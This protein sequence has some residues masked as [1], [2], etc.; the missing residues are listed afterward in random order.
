MSMMDVTVGVRGVP[1]S[2]PDYSKWNVSLRVCSCQDLPRSD[3]LGSSDPYVRIVVRDGDQDSEPLQLR[4]FTCYRTRNPV[5]DDGAE[6]FDLANLPS[7]GCRLEF[8]VVDK[9]RGRSAGEGDAVVGSATMVFGPRGA[10]SDWVEHSLPLYHGSIGQ[11]RAAA[12]PG[13][14]RWSATTAGPRRPAAGSDS[15]SASGSAAVSGGGAASAGQQL[16]RSGAVPSCSSSAAQSDAGLSTGLLLTRTPPVPCLGGPWGAE[17]EC[18]ASTSEGGKASGGRGLSRRASWDGGGTRR[19]GRL[20]VQLRWSRSADRLGHPEHRGPARFR[21]TLS[22]L[23]GMLTAAAGAAWRAYAAYKVVLPGCRL[24]FPHGDAQPWNAGYAAAAAIF[25]SASARHAVRASHRLLYA[26]AGKA[27]GKHRGVL[28]GAA[29][30]AALLWDG[31]P[32]YYTYVL[33]GDELRFSETGAA[34]FYDM[35]SKLRD[36]MADCFPDLDVDT[37]DARDP[38][39]AALHALVPSRQAAASRAVVVETPPP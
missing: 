13:D 31:A 10:P 30:W 24:H 20:V 36:L 23:P 17:A 35:I 14:R 38:A 37:I 4:T 7:T 16:M 2:V 11:H 9:G 19:A 34:F 12:A 5:W 21:R 6:E 15:G 39:L 29:D 33:L 8:T 28:R 25:G 26:D 1:E 22:S 32:R 27:T 3:V 18:A